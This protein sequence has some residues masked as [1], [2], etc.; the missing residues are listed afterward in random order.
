[1]M[2]TSRKSLCRYHP[3]VF[4]RWL[5]LAAI[6]VMVAQPVFAQRVTIPSERLAVVARGWNQFE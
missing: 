5:V 2:W 3:L 1:M 6:V 4:R